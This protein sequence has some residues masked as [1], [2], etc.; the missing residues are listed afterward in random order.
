MSRREVYVNYLLKLINVVGGFGATIVVLFTE[1]NQV[2]L[3]RKQHMKC[4]DVIIQES[5]DN[6]LNASIAKSTSTPASLQAV[7]RIKKGSI[8]HN[9]SVCV[10]Y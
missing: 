8:Q 6:D 5:V 2:H 7:V 10:S 9:V 3:L 1:E 4:A